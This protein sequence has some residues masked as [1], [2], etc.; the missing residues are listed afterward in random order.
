[1]YT[2]SMTLL[3]HLPIITTP[4]ELYDRILST[5]SRAKLRKLRFQAWLLCSSALV[6]LVY[7]LSFWG[8]WVNE[9]QSS[10]FVDFFKLL[11]SDPDIVFASIGTFTIGVLE[12]IPLATS[13]LIL[14]NAL[15]I[16]RSLILFRELKLST[17]H[18]FI[19][20]H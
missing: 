18:S 4:P 12:S 10:E 3:T 6:T 14:I 7:T 5:V 2:S 13:I 16:L 19:H 15:L 17:S 20:A 11:W 8:D 9:F 1:M